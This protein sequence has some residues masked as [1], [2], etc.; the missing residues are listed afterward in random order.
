MKTEPSKAY[1]EALKATQHLHAT[2]KKFNGRFFLRYAP[3]VAPLIK[4]H[5][6]KTL[7]DYGCGKGV[8]WKR[9]P[10]GTMLADQ[11]GVEVAMY[12]PGWPPVAKEPQGRFDIVVCTQV[13]GSVP[14]VDLPW[15]IGR[16]YGF[17]EKAVYIGERIKP[18]R[19][20]LH[21]HMAAQ[22]PHEKPHEWWAEQLRSVPIPDGL[23]V[24]LRTFDSISGE[25]KLEIIR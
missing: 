19:K 13:M 25:D 3:D 14:I 20:Q 1:F 2:S 7:L 15:F 5:E 24:V 23:P 16:L 9:Q 21:A 8:Q 10:D 18:V 6:C 12:D 22:M 17:A 11:L 4:A